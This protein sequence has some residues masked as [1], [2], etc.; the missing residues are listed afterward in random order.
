MHASQSARAYK[1]AMI[2]CPGRW[3]HIY[4]IKVI[5]QYLSA[6]AV[7]ATALW[8]NGMTIRTP[9]RPQCDGPRIRWGFQTF[10]RLVLDPHQL[11]SGFDP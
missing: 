10:E 7:A 5:E 1:T 2:G 9:Q 3:V 6:T 4:G 8:K 11:E